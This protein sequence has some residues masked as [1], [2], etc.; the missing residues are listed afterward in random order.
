MA[1][2]TGDDLGKIRRG[3]FEMATKFRVPA[4]L[5]SSLELDIFSHIQDNGTLPEVIAAAVNVVPRRLAFLI[6][7]LVAMELLTWKDGRYFVPK[8][9]A[10]FLRRGPDYLGD[11]L[12]VHKAENEHWL[13]MTNVINGS[14]EGDAFEDNFLCGPM[15]PYY[16]GSIERNNRPHADAMW[17]QLSQ[18]VP[19]LRDVLDL[20]GGHGYFAESLLALNQSTTITIFDLPGAIDYCIEKQK[21]R[22]HFQRLNFSAGDARTIEYCEKFDLVMCNDLLHYFSYDEKVEVVRRAF[23]AL[24]SGGMLA[25][26]KIHLAASGNSPANATLFSMRMFM[27]TLGAYLETDQELE[28]VLEECGLK[29][30]QS[31]FLN[32]NK[33]KV[34]IT[35]IK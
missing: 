35:G 13:K 2:A 32:E 10:P 25:L 31:V 29:D 28:S 22:P 33:T 20:G 6:D 27:G 16:L 14:F 1:I 26:A 23:R 9:L 24:K 11:Y 12:L 4:V 18:I 17:K 34:L 30:I 8:N 19:N 21:L 7:T 15:A 3:F 5:F